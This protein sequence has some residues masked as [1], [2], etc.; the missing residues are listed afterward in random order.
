MSTP[1]PEEQF[2]CH[3]TSLETAVKIL[4]SK[5]LWATD[6]R[7]LDDT[8]EGQFLIDVFKEL[9]TNT[10]DD[11]QLELITDNFRRMQG[12]N[13]F[14]ISSF[15]LLPKDKIH[16]GNLSMG[17]YFGGNDWVGLVFNEK[18]IKASF[19]Q[20]LLFKRKDCLD[21]SLLQAKVIYEGKQT[22]ISSVKN[23]YKAIP[24]LINDAL[25]KSWGP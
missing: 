17:R 25:K 18:K 24:K 19:E 12:N 3:Y 5:K 6:S 10:E 14:Y 1:K 2:L 4:N 16:Y 7:F 23:G 11:T 13:R 21:L 15:S 9:K 22:M 8:S 20:D